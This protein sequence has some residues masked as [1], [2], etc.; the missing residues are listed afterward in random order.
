MN[1]PFLWA[2]DTSVAIPYVMANHPA[3]QAVD[4]AVAGRVLHLSGHAHVETYAVL[5]RLPGTSRLTPLD[6]CRLIDANFR[7]TLVAPLSIQASAPSTLAHAG[8]AGGATYDGLVALASKAHG[9]I[10]LTRDARALT[11]YQRIGVE[12]E[13]LSATDVT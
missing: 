1:D 12:V 2:V 9:A 7:S 6:A 11:T 8:I 3:H 4:R 5:T 13:V 10:L